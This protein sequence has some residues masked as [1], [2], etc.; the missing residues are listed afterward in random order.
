MEVNKEISAS[1]PSSFSTLDGCTA[2]TSLLIAG[3]VSL[4]L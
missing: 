1:Q 2:V 4:S 3:F